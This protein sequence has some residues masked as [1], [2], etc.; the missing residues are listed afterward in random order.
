M[1]QGYSK[2]LRE[3]SG[4]TQDNICY[5]IMVLTNVFNEVT[6]LT[7]ML[8]EVSTF[9]KMVRQDYE[10]QKYLDKVKKSSKTFSLD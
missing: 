3:V 6:A 2:T 4:S 9:R 5:K 7:N 10:T 8:L 1:R